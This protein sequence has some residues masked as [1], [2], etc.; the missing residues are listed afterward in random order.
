MNVLQVS[1]LDRFRRILNGSLNVVV[2]GAK[3]RPRYI[4]SMTAAMALTVSMAASTGT[5]HAQS[6]IS[7]DNQASSQRDRGFAFFLDQRH[8]MICIQVVTRVAS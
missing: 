2:N 5:V 6:K 8:S 7:A 1:G 4:V 3:T